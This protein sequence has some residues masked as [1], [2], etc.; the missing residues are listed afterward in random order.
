MNL[1]YIRHGEPTYEP[2][3][4]TERGRM[5]AEALAG[6]LADIRF[7]A[8]YSST[9]Q[10]ALETAG[11]T[12]KRLG[13]TVKPL[14]WCN[15]KYAYEEF[16]C[17]DEADGRRKWLYEIEGVK[18]IFVSPE[19]EG[20]AAAWY[21]SERFFDERFK[22]G[23]ERIQRAGFAFLETLG[24]VYDDKK[25][26]YHVRNKS[27]ANIALFAHEG[28]GTVLLSSVLGIPYPYFCTH[29]SLGFCG[30][31]V[32]SFEGEPLAVPKVS[33]LFEGMKR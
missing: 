1:Y 10:R 19:F 16:S 17:I 33:K 5:Q 11:P 29:F 15:E 9:S 21:Q 26:A 32:I 3:M 23:T 28:V 18:R 2:D 20:Q 24:Y 13:L 12:A 25:G 14:D 7:D 4:L 31:L 8:I 30:F 6:V 22:A 27:D